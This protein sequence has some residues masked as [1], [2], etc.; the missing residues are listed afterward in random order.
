MY[1]VARKRSHTHPIS[2]SEKLIIALMQL[3]FWSYMTD[4]DVDKSG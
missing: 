3:Q 1:N 2:S 4:E